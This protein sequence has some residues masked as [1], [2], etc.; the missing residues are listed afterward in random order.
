MK[1]GEETL[2]ADCRINWVHPCHPHPHFNPD[3]TKLAFHE[4]DDE[5]QVV[6]GIMEI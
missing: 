2:L 6:V 1:T 4:L 5:G 3:D